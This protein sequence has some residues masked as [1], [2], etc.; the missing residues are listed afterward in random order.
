MDSV[1]EGEL[2]HKIEPRTIQEVKTVYLGEEFQPF[3]R[4]SKDGLSEGFRNI[5]LLAIPNT[6]VPV[7]ISTS[8]Y[9]TEGRPWNCIFPFSTSRGYKINEDDYSL[10]KRIKKMEK[11]ISKVDV[12]YKGQEGEEGDIILAVNSLPFLSFST[13]KYFTNLNIRDVDKEIIKNL[14][15]KNTYNPPTSDYGDMAIRPEILSVLENVRLQVNF[16]TG[17]YE[18]MVEIGPYDT[19]IGF[20]NF[21]PLS[22]GPLSTGAFLPDYDSMPLDISRFYTLS[23]EISYKKGK[24]IVL[25][26]DPE[27][28]EL[29]K[30][31]FVPVD[32]NPR[33]S[34]S[35]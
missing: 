28:L 25:P 22:R 32:K 23:H 27:K 19:V 1:P 7:D 8:S 17:E 14:I 34:L 11:I 3:K 24:G 6:K 5:M 29:I 2:R 20:Y 21:Y 18:S 26:S 4:V 13:N 35:R 10:E 33:H 31:K 9:K 16:P 15:T 12:G 30:M